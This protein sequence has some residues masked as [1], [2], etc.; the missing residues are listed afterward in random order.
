MIAQ[1]SPNGDSKETPKTAQRTP[2]EVL[3]MATGMPMKAPMRLQELP[4]GLRRSP[5]DP[6]E[7]L[8][9]RKHLMQ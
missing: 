6:K 2:Q 3:K 5:R 9:R 8:K 4:G 1:E 7:A